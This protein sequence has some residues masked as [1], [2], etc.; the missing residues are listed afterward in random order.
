MKKKIVLVFLSVAVLLGLFLVLRKVIPYNAKPLGSPEG[1]VL[2]GY[3]L[4]WGTVENATGYEVEVDGEIRAVKG[5]SADMRYSDNGKTVRIRAVGDGKGHLNSEF[6]TPFVLEY[7]KGLFSRVNLVHYVLEEQHLTRTEFIYKNRIIPLTPFDYSPYG[8]DFVCWMRIVD[9]KK[10]PVTAQFFH[11]GDVYLYASVIAREYPVDFVSEDFPLPSNLPSTY[12]A[13][14]LP[15]ILSLRIEHGGYRVS[16]WYSDSELTRPVEKGTVVT[17]ALTL[18]LR[19]SLINEGLVLDRIEGGYAVVGFSGDGEVVHVPAY[20]NGE[21][22]LKVSKGGLVGSVDDGISVRKIVFYGDIT[23][24]EGAVGGMLQLEEC[25]F[26][27]SATVEN[28]AFAFTAIHASDSFS[29][30]AHSALNIKAAFFSYY[31]GVEGEIFFT[32]Y[33]SEESYPLCAEALLGVCEVKII[34]KG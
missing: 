12:T 15:E 25:E 3:T 21:R 7:D 31:L 28:G 5:A 16:G 22:V 23:L 27:G 18:Y 17:G 34:G 9:G 4:S 1:I 30:V 2:E 32:V 8:Y 14:T 19:I 29:I 26:L 20:Y 11:D 24:E 13:S 33:T 6:C 10:V